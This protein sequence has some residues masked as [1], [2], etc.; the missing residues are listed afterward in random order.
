MNAKIS[1]SKRDKVQ[2]GAGKTAPLRSGDERVDAGGCDHFRFGSW[3][4][5]ISNRES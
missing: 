4:R 3:Q 2:A 1:V 5:E